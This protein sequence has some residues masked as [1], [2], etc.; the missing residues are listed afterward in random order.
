MV[1][2]SLPRREFEKYG[3]VKKGQNF[4]N[5]TKLVDTGIYAII[6]HHFWLT[7]ILL[8]VAFALLSQFI[9]MILL[10]LLVSGLVYIETFHL[11]KRLIIKFGEDYNVCKK[12]VPRMNIV[13]GLIKYYKKQIK[14]REEVVK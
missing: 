6:R 13:L 9:I 4:L 8:S 10:S 11:D 7:W 3:G 1:I 14:K 5:T 2:G 12:K